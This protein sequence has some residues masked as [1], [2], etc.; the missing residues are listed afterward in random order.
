MGTASFQINSWT[1]AWRGFWRKLAPQSSSSDCIHLQ[2]LWRRICTKPQGILIQG[3][4]YC[5][6][7]CLEQALTDALRR[8]QSTSLRV[9]PPHRIPLGLLLLSRQQLT[10]EQ[11]RI[12]LEN[13]RAAGCGRIG[14][15]LQTLGFV[16][17]Q[18]VTAA[19]ARQWSCPVLRMNSQVPA[20]DIPQIPATLLASFVMMPVGYVQARSTLHVAFSGGIDYSVLYAMEQMIGC[21]TE[22]CMAAPSFV[23]QRLGTIVEDRSKSEIVF[24]RVADD[25]E[26]SRIVRSY[27]IGVAAKEVRLAVCG[28]YLWVRLLRSSYPPLDLL[29]HSSHC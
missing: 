10:V 8:V 18:Q 23:R 7:K 5:P 3:S 17:E 12:G 13:Q 29:L 4:R 6:K 24:D 14:E 26:F 27:S 1:L 25:A 9:R 15:W 28:P 20:G 16:N 19:L 21:H 11:L 2:G 22:P